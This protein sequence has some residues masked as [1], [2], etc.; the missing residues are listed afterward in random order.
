MIRRLLVLFAV[1][2]LAFCVAPRAWAGDGE[3]TPAASATRIRGWIVDLGSE[4]FETRESATKNLE[5]SGLAGVAPLGE[6]AAGATLEV[7]GRAIRALQCIAGQD[8]RV[9]FEAAEVVLERLAESKNRSVSRRASVALDEL[10]VLRRKYA[11]I[12][13]A[14]LGGIV[15]ALDERGSRD[16]PAVQVSV[17]IDRRWKGG[18]QGLVLVRRWHDSEGAP[19]HHLYVIAG[20]ALS[21]DALAEL[22]RDCPQLLIESRGPAMLGVRFR[23]RFEAI[24]TVDGVQRGS[25]A[26]KAGVLPNDVI[27]KYDGERLTDFRRLIEITGNHSA[28]DKIE[29]EVLRDGR[30]VKLEAVLGDWQ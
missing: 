25:A 24:C 1:G 27:L 14:E 23:E 19:A 3:P 12:R 21:A 18:D 7:A 22:K 26:E 8:E 9:S 20:A 29:L 10:S 5:R 17:A 11:L 2:T 15:K 30:I 16:D 28:G 6:A 4:R 13:I